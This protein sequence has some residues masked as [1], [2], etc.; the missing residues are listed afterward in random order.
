MLTHRT[1]R[2]PAESDSAGPM[3]GVPTEGG[4]APTGQHS[5][6]LPGVAFGGSHSGHILLRGWRNKSILA[7]SVTSR[8][9]EVI[10]V[11]A[12]SRH[13]TLLPKPRSMAAHGLPVSLASPSQPGVAA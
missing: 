7:E 5:Y 10:S 3:P 2:T 8:C 1:Y 6:L 12:R 13:S 11:G 9:V 4:D